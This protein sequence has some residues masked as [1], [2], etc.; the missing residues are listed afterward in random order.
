MN[1]RFDSVFKRYE[2]TIQ[3]QMPANWTSRDE[4][5]KFARNIWSLAKEI[6]GQAYQ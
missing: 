5:E 4:V 2:V 6:A 1:G 3:P